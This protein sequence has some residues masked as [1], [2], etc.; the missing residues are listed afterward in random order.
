MIHEEFTGRAVYQV[1]HGRV[2]AALPVVQSRCDRSKLR[3]T[4][5]PSP[6]QTGSEGAKRPKGRNMKVKALAVAV[7][8]GLSFTAPVLAQHAGHGQ[9]PQQSAPRKQLPRPIPAPPPPPK[10]LLPTDTM[11][12]QWMEMMV[13]I[14]PGLVLKHRDALGLSAEQAKRM[15]SLEQELNTSAAPHMRIAM[16]GHPSALDLLSTEN[17]D[18]PLHE[19]KLRQHA[20]HMVQGQMAMIR[21]AVHTRRSLSA[22]QQE[23]LAGLIPAATHASMDCPMMMGNAPSNDR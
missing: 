12:A 6:D 1:G 22:E 8:A 20:D 13:G 15:G 7:L 16:S 18:L 9:P 2:V 5:A 4:T 10:A 23:K 21:I 19:Q 11:A 17:P 3:Q 14:T